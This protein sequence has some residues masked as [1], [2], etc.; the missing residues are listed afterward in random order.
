MTDQE[1]RR[2]CTCSDCQQVRKAL[3]LLDDIANRPTTMGME[4]VEDLCEAREILAEQIGFTYDEQE[5][6]YK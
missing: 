6:R 4:D 3:S 1:S 5:Q 2:A